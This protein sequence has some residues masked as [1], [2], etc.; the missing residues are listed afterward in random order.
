MLREK[1]KKKL[2]NNPFA[3]LR[4]RRMRKHLINHDMTL[5]CPNCMGGTLFHDLGLQFRSPT[6]NLMMYQTDFLKFALDLDHYLNSD[7]KFFKSPDYDF[8]CAKL[9]DITIHFSHYASQEEA[10]QT[11][12]RRKARIDKQNMFVVCSERDGLTKA[13]ILRLGNELKVRGLLVFTENDYPEIPYTL[14]IKKDGVGSILQ[15]VSFLTYEEKFE[16]VFDFV[17]WFN[18]ADG[19]NYDITPYIKP[20]K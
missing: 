20:Q 3:Q 16:R 10:L 9:S 1:L 17:S 18:Q 11:W 13:D 4:R 19:G 2:K 8:P 14:Q 5:L 15:R 7:F 6:I 12:N